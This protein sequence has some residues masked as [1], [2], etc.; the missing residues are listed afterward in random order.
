[1]TTKLQRRGAIFRALTEHEVT[2]QAQLCEILADRG[3]AT[4]QAT[5][6]RDLEEL[7][8]SR[9]RGTDGELIYVLPGADPPA[10]PPGEALRRALS[11][12]VVECQRSGELVVVRT[13]PGH[14]QLVASAIDRARLPGVIGSVA[15]DDTVLVV[16]RRGRG[17]HVLSLLNAT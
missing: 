7:G 15:G 2:S 16:A 14:A 11:E 6:S 4:T 10:P 8:V 1:M 3:I 9:S 12:H 5:V 13:P 17:A